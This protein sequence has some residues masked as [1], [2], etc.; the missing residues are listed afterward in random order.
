MAMR[1]ENVVPFGRSLDEYSKMFSLTP[2]DLE[3]PIIGVGDGPASFNAELSS[4]GKSVT[5]VDP[6]YIF[7]AQTIEK[8][9][10]SVVDNIIEQVKASP[11]DWSWSYHLSPEHLKRARIGVLQR[12]LADFEHGKK[13]GRY[14]VGELPELDFTDN[15]FHLALCSHFLFLYSEQLSY[16]FHRASV[17]E[18]LRVAE[19]VR[20]FPLLTLM[21]NNSPYVQPLIAE[22]KSEGFYV[23]VEKVEYELQKG[24]NEMLRIRRTAR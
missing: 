17:C 21:R 14:T 11:D 23:Q 2:D 18:M 12:F 16:E 22:L 20:I 6:L 13:A 19:E 8:R 15:E 3:R 1:L 10:N 9:F 24:G 5:S 4:L 7:D